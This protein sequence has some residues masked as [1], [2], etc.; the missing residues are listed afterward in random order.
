MKVLFI[1]SEKGFW[2]EECFTP[3]NKISKKHEVT[4]ATPTGEKPRPDEKSLE[5]GD[6]ELMEENNELNSP[7]SASKAYRKRQEYDAVVLPGGHGTLWDINQDVHVQQILKEKTEK[8]PA[9][10]I[11][12]AVGILGFTPELTEG[13]EVTGFPNQWEDGQVDENEVRN[14]EKLP[15]RVEDLVKEAGAE[16]D[17]EL[18]KDTS[19]T[20]DGNLITARGPDSSEKGAEKFLE[21]AS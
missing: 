20:V 9:L 6:Q 12:H 7:I 17:A 5:E 16:W 8:G 18:D 21:K 4:V 19:V 10:V 11:C 2:A 3:L 1:V 15:Y 13:R 14:G